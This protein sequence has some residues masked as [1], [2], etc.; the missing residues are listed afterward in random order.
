MKLVKNKNGAQYYVFE[1]FEKTGLVNH[2]FSTRKGGVSKGCFE[3]LNLSFRNDKKENVIEN[4]RLLCEA[5]GCDYN[6][7][8][9]S[10]QIHEDNLYEAKN[11][12]RG[13]GLLKESDIIGYDGLYTNNKNI[14]L[15]TFYADCV[16]LFFLDV[17]KKVIAISHS[18]W[19]GTVKK[20]GAKTVDTLKKRYNSLE[21]DII[22]GIGPSIG[23]CCFEVD[24]PV[25]DVFLEKLPF[26]K[27]FIIKEENK[28]KYRID[29]QSINKQ[30]LINAGLK[31][32]NIEVADL[33][34][35]CMSDIF[36]SH[37]VMGDERGSMAALMELKI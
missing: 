29:L 19:K 23:L 33:C 1:S 9:F 16:P 15:T 8:V 18:G 30:I 27:K 36:Y 14:V 37:R 12:D 11:D 3:S 6:N 22:A 10:N 32:K 26:C 34:T 17:S 28:N 24:K 2:C 31:E 35:K 7:T 25:A 13:K 4:Y 20:I 5:I 21:D